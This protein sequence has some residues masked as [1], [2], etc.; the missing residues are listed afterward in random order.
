MYNWCFPSWNS[1]MV[2]WKVIQQFHSWIHSK[3]L[4]LGLKQV[5]V[6]QYCG[7]L[8]ENV[9]YKLIYLNV[10]GWCL[11]KPEKS[12]IFS[13]TVVPDSCD[14]LE[15]VLESLL[16]SLEEKEVLKIFIEK[17]VYAIYFDHGF[18]SPN[19]S[20]IIP[21]SFST[22]LHIFL[23]LWKTNKKNLKRHK[24][25]NTPTQRHLS[26]AEIA[27]IFKFVA[28]LCVCVFHLHVCKCT[29]CM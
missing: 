14:P 26:S 22:Q 5:F 17:N 23:F 16:C 12:I 24:T 8:N 18:P 20:Q 4:S 21:T 10:C 11:W 15:L 6:H 29:I 27:I 3:E 19:S 2:N 13:G 9:P 25:R 7:G 1:S 28:I